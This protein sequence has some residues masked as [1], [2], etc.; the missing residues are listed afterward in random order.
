M[1]EEIPNTQAKPG[2]HFASRKDVAAAGIHKPL[3]A[4]IAGNSITGAYSIVL[5]G[6][7][8]D[9]EDYGSVI[10]YTGGGGRDNST[11]KQIV[12]QEL[13][14]VNLA[15]ATSKH[16]NLPV[17]V[18]RGSGHKSQYSPTEGYTYSGDYYVT[19][20]WHE[21]GKSGHRIYR[22]RLEQL[23]QN[24]IE[25]ATLPVSERRKY[26]VQRIIRDSKA[27]RF[28][29]EIY[30]YHCQ[31][32]NIKISLPLG[33]AYAE[34]AHIKPLGRPHEGPDVI[35]NLLCLC[36]NHHVM[37]DNYVFSINPTDHTLMGIEGSLNVNPAHNITS[38]YLEYHNRLFLAK[39]SQN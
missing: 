37:F 39:S 24:N 2:S 28:I 7:Y 3:I 9:D 29:K 23:P 6:G 13:T 22:Y 15:L 25:E 17:R 36:P 30:D 5:S 10:V 31:V 21:I 34:G 27:S 38:E 14:G 19:D 26:E 11:G 20:Y 18:T 4:G 1:T 32:C 33:I 12:D 8:E 16:K 35:E